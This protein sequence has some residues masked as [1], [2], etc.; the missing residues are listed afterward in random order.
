MARN[1]HVTNQSFILGTLDDFVPQ[2]H[3]VRK[4]DEFI[5]RNFIY[6]ICDPLYSKE[7]TNRVD[8]V[9]LFKMMFINIIFGIH[10]MKKTCEEVKVNIAY[11]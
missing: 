7:G 3:F 9:I 1:R 4:L 8:P 6:E 10:S 5:D 11:K 2:D